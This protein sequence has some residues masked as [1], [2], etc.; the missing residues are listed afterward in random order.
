MTMIHH[1]Y[2]RSGSLRRQSIS[3]HSVKP[4]TTND[5]GP[6]SGPRKLVS[7]PNPKNGDMTRASRDKTSI[8]MDGRHE[9]LHC[10]KAR[11]GFHQRDDGPGSFAGRKTAGGV[12]RSDATVASGSGP[13]GT[14]EKRGT[15]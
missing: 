5:K 7:P 12:S 10:V 8:E 13:T 2:C 9:R 14:A 4:A 6:D 1:Q 11:G 15:R 3:I